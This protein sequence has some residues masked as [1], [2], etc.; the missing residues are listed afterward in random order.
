[1]EKYFFDYRPKSLR[2]MPIFFDFRRNGTGK[3]L[4]ARAIHERISSQDD[5]SSVSIWVHLPNPFSNQEL[6]GHKRAHSLMRKKIGAGRFEVADNG[7]PFLR[8]NRKS[9]NASHPNYW[10]YSKSG[11][12]P[13][14][15][16]NKFNSVA[17][18]LICATNLHVHEMV[19]ENTFSSKILT[20]SNQF[21]VEIFS[22][23][24]D[25]HDDIPVFWPNHFLKS[26]GQEIQKEFRS[27]TASALDLPQRYGWPGN[28]RELQHCHR[29]SHNYGE[30]DQLD[31]RWLLFPFC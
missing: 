11:K 4:I 16:T 28:I 18:G 17:F 23:A 19:M 9:I 3:E 1:M 5:T 21:T 2:P 26:Y 24:R 27:F 31:A 8:W 6:F 15:R 30:G 20:L 12:S 13:K 7:N 29:A 25:R 22:T 14:S 10:Q